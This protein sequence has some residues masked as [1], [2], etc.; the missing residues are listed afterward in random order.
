MPN[1]LAEAT[2][3]YLLQHADNPVDW[4]QWGEAAFAEAGRRGVPILLSVGYASCHWCHVMAHE[5]FEDEA[6]A[7]VMNERFVNVKVDREERPDVDRIY[8]DAVQTISGRG[9][10]PMTVFLTPQGQPFFAGTYYPPE[11]RHGH[12]SFRRVMDA[13]HDAWANRRAEVEEQAG[14]LT[15]VISTPVPPA[16]GVPGEE[17]TRSAYRSLSGSFDRRHGGF[18]GAPKFPQVPTL[19]FLLRAVGRPWAPAAAEMVSTT[20]HAMASGGINDV[21]G[22]GFAR[23]S[24]DERWLVPHFEKMLYDNALLARL[25]A[26]AAQVTGDRRLGDVARSTIDYML[27]DLRLPSGGFASGEDADSEGT[28]GKFY[29]FSH[30]EFMEVVG[31]DD[32]RLAAPA[33]GVTPDG[34]F[35]GSNILHRALTPDQ[36]ANTTG[37]TANEVMA[38]VERARS[39]LN[40]RR[41]TRVRP[42]LDDKVVCAWNGMAIRALAEAGIAI[43]EPSYI[44]AAAE[45]AQFVLTEMRDQNGLLRR[46]WREG[47]RSGQGFCDDYGAMAVALF[48]LYRATG[49]PSWYL[50]AADI[51]NLMVDRFADREDGGFFATAIDV[52]YLIARPKNVFDNPTPSDNALAAEALLH[53]AAYTGNG[54]TRDLVDGTLRSAGAVFD[55][56]PYGAGRLLTVL[57]DAAGQREVA[58]VGDPKDPATAALVQVALGGYRPGV[59]VAVDPGGTPDSETMPLLHGRT[60]RGIPL[61]YVCRDHVCDAPVGD[62]PALEALLA[63]TLI[64]ISAAADTPITEHE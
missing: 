39:A 55:R 45:T 28:E 41:A 58:I 63:D 37:A 54:A 4:F 29:V 64:K 57:L 47:R 62:A 8:M 27:A 21:L 36:V 42:G 50:E 33:L 25:Y 15:Q 6:T 22:G 52:E 11:D 30:D 5:S 32:G 19:E 2:S 10:W 35:E 18:G 12:P 9:G 13:V 20:L 53:L 59:Y 44:T 49:D 3:P 40:D 7:A 34:N 46:S 51:T 48:S 61:A 26:R 56:A 14:R 17:A 16:D 43:S 60:G 38:A 24:V 31:A 23:Y 1:R